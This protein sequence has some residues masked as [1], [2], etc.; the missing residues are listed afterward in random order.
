[1]SGITLL[2]EDQKKLPKALV[3]KICDPYSTHVRASTTRRGLF[4]D[5]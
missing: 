4:A 5:A 3:A 2:T 1:M